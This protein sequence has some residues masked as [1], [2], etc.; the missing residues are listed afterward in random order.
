M[1]RP[2]SLAFGGWTDAIPNMVASLTD[3]EKCGNAKF[4]IGNDSQSMNI[5]PGDAQR[6]FQSAVVAQSQLKRGGSSFRGSLRAL[7]LGLGSDTRNSHRSLVC[8]TRGD[9]EPA[10][11][12]DH[13]AIDLLDSRHERFL[14]LGKFD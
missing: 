6:S 12:A 1:I 4:P 2:N 11:D 9:A 5:P 14:T 3:P 7:P 10:L 8:V 13:F